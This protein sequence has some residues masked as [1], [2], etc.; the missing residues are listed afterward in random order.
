MAS[1]KRLIELSM[2]P[3]LAKEVATQI[4]GAIAAKPAVTAIVSLT[5]NS[6]GA[7]A[8]NTLVV[9]PAATAATTDTS[10]ASLTSTN[11]AITAIKNDLA[12]LAGKVNTIIAAL[13]A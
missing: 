3:I 12:D 5:D 4:D 10:A 7:A 8:D 1:A 6:G 11:T 13:K 9:V 2:V